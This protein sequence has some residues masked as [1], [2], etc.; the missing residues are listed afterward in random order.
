[1]FAPIHMPWWLAPTGIAVLVLGLLALALAL[2]GDWWRRGRKAS[3]LRCPRC[4]YDMRAA[5]DRRCPECGRVARS[6]RA[7]R[8]SRRYWGRAGLALLVAGSGTLAWRLESLIN[9]NWIPRTPNWLLVWIVR[10]PTIAPTPRF[11]NPPTLQEAL[12]EELWTRYGKGELTLD[13]RR[14][15]TRRQFTLGSAPLRVDSR[16]EWPPDG[17]I[18]Y[19]VRLC[20]GGPLGR[21]LRARQVGTDHGA[22]ISATMEGGWPS[23]I[24][25]AEW[26]LRRAELPPHATEIAFDVEVYER[27]GELLWTGRAASPI[28]RVRSASEI[29]EPIRDEATNAEIEAA[30]RRGLRLLPDRNALTF[31]QPLTQKTYLVTL[32][33][34]VELLRYENCIATADLVSTGV[35]HPDPNETAEKRFAR[36]HLS[37]DSADE[38]TRELKGAP[39]ELH[40][41]I[42]SG[43]EWR[44][45]VSGNAE[46]ALRDFAATKYWAGEINLPARVLTQ[47]AEADPDYDGPP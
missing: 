42:L 27:G 23:A 14:E 32:G 35:R 43:A 22:L 46:L 26:I 12:A 10:N 2:L 17:D 16:P 1:M 18:W 45:R 4:W 21:E 36:R 7:L 13:Q 40:G 30:L 19:T 8:R 11:S 38:I 31:R 5:I 41:A 44:V 37:I 3:T 6:E 39:A 15:I 24:P 25:E 29:L 34:V 20:F 28:T 47:P 33:L 9:S